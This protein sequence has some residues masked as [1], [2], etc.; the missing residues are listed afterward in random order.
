MICGRTPPVSSS[1]HD[2]SAKGLV[3]EGAWEQGGAEGTFRDSA[4]VGRTD[5]DS[6]NKAGPEQ[7]GKLPPPLGVIE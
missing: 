4:V 5:G 2:L 6:G 7:C 3:A 1:T